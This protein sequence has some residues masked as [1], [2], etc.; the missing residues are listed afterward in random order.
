MWFCLVL[1]TVAIAV[2]YSALVGG[3]PPI[4]ATVGALIGSGVLG[5][6]LFVIQGPAGAP[7]RRLPFAAFIIISSLV[8]LGIIYAGLE[9]GPR[10]FDM[11]P[12]GADY[13]ATTLS[14]DLSFAF[15]I[16]LIVNATL[17]VRT[18]V[19]PRVLS[20]FLLGRY[21]RPEEENRIFMFLDLADSTQLSE[22]LGALRVQA[23]IREFFDDVAGP[24]MYFN[25]ETH[26]Y[27]GDEVVV[28]WPLTGTARDQDC[29]KCVFAVQDRI[30]RRADYYQREYGVVPRF[31]VGL[32][33]GPVV[34]SEI[35]Q[36][37]REIV[38]FGDTINTAARLA[39]SCKQLGCEVLISKVLAERL[40]L[41]EDLVEW[42]EATLELAGKSAPFRALS[43]TATSATPISSD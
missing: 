36:D 31:R 40:G 25:G 6:E 35:G 21:Y 4:A 30:R 24:V 10:L 5:L 37:K 11:Q 17:R 42:R 14:Q 23:L 29:V 19:G 7:L 15:I 18:L 16:T 2:A 13:D 26:R 12:Y 38:Y 28:I 1:L 9:I 32:H 27:I 34:V 20:N 22:Q 8:W 3:N 33:G 39:S 41:P 43:A